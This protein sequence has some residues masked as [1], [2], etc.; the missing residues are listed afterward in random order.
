MMVMKMM[1][2]K[3]M[4]IMMMVMVMMMIMMMM[5][6]EVFTFLK[7]Q[8]THLSLLNTFHLFEVS[9]R[10]LIRCKISHLSRIRTT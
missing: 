3:L 4:V 7:S 8:S 5:I 2:V 9:A 1:M 6:F 10:K